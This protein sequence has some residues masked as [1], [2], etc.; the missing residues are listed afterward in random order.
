MSPQDA[1]VGQRLGKSS[2]QNATSCVH[3]ATAER[4]RYRGTWTVSPAALAAD[5]S[6]AS[7]VMS[8]ARAGARERAVARW[9]ASRVRIS[10]GL[11]VDAVRI[12]P[13][14]SRTKAMRRRM[15]SARSATARLAPDRS[16]ARSTSTQASTLETIS[17]SERRV[18]TSAPVSGSG[19][20]S[21]TMAE[22]SRYSIA[23]ALQPLRPLLAERVAQ[24]SGDPTPRWKELQKV[25]FRRRGPSRAHQ[26]LQG[27]RGLRQRREHGDRSPT[28]GHLQA[29]PSLDPS[30][31]NAEVLAEL[32][33]PDLRPTI[34]HVAHSSTSH[35]WPG[36]R[37]SL[38]VRVGGRFEPLPEV[39]S[40]ETS[41]P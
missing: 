37:G 1:S 35:S 20:T 41:S 34:T 2:G 16:T 5:A 23:A 21:F 28:L 30:Q 38:G 19:T 29:L 7:Y 31:V 8:P 22:E 13:S 4:S 18:W 12:T 32:P 33:N 14:S 10:W 6:R 27:R 3:N 25:A 24:A 39:W 26:L 9:I 11:S 17:G 36:G 40:C 15:D